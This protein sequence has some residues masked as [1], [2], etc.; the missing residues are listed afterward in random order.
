MRWKGFIFIG[1]FIALLLALPYIFGDNWLEKKV[2]KAA[3]AINGAKVEIDNFD[4]SL[5]SSSVSWDRMQVANSDAPMKNII[6]TGKTGVD[7]KLTALI[8]RRVVIDSMRLTEVRTNTDRETSGEL[9]KKIKKKTERETP[10][11]VDKAQKKLKSKA[12]DY[13]STRIDEMKSDLNVDSM[14]LAIDLAS[15]DYIDSVKNV[16]EARYAHWDTIVNSEELQQDLT[17]LEAEYKK[18]QEIDPKKINDINDLKKTIKKLEKAKKKFDKVYDKIKK[19]EKEFDRDL[20]DMQLA[21]EVVNDKI[22]TDYREIEAMAKI[23]DIDTKNMAAFIFGETVV[24]RVNKFLEITEKIRFYKN[25]LQ[26][27]EAEQDKRQRHEGKYIHFSDKYQYPGFWIKKAVLSG[28]LDNQA[29]LSGKINN[30]VSD[31]KLINSPTT[32]AIKGINPDDSNF[33]IQAF[34]DNR[35]KDALDRYEINYNGLKIRDFTVS[36]SSLF[37]YD[38]KN[39]IGNI[40]GSIEINRENYEG[41]LTFDG[42]G[43][44]FVRNSDEKVKTEVQKLIHQ[45]VQKLDE[46]TVTGKFSNES[47]AINSNIDNVFGDEIKSYINKNVAEAKKEVRAEIDQKVKQARTEFESYKQSAT[48]DI[49]E[50][51]Q[52]YKAEI[53]KYLDEIDDKQSAT[54]KEIKKKGKKALED[55]F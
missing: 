1:I 44:N 40:S 23:P 6:E 50:Q 10:G 27:T 21:G 25:K 20:K 32:A 5:F 29:L 48:G 49:E 46:L 26:K 12:E 47:L 11:I 54:E 18:L 51:L 19:H 34:I 36:K 55:L 4:L 31:Q 45:S 53:E 22:K 28:E 42:S 17:E 41:R 52:A 8:R 30:I 43:M 16:F 38:I 24:N 3:S 15:V 9:P 39:G 33:E 2:E 35:T 14:M 13:K 7:L 37:P